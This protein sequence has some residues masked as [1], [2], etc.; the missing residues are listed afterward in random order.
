MPVRDF[1]RE[2]QWLLPPSLDTMI[3]DTHPVRYVAMFIDEIPL[4]EWRELGIDPA[5]SHYGR[6]SYSIYA[7]VGIWLY[8]F[9]TGIRTSRKLERA[10]EEQVPFLWL[11]GMEQPDFR[12]LWAFYAAHRHGM[13]QLLQRTVQVAAKA[14]LVDLAVQAID[15]TK[16][17]ANA[18]RDRYRSRTG[19]QELLARTT[20]AI[21]DLESQNEAETVPLPTLPKVLKSKER[22]RTRILAALATLPDVPES[23]DE[24]ADS[25]PRSTGVEPPLDAPETPTTVTTKPATKKGKGKGKNTGTPSSPTDP[26]DRGP[27]ANLTDP[28]AKLMQG[29]YGAIR[30]LY[31][32]QA[33]TSPLLEG[34]NREK[35]V[36][37]TAPSVSCH[38]ADVHELI[39]M[40]K[41]AEAV[42]GVRATTVGDGGYHSAANI[43]AA[44]AR[45][46]I[47]V[48]PD[49][50]TTG[51]RKLYPKAL[52]V[53]DSETDTFRC[54]QGQTLH[55]LAGEFHREEGRP[56]ATRY[57]AP[58]SVCVACP[59]QARCMQGEA[60]TQQHGRM[61]TV[62][63]DETLLRGHQELMQQE[64]VKELYAYRKTWSEATFGTLKNEQNARIFLLR[65]LDK[66]TDEWF[67]LATAFN[68]R[69]LWKRWSLLQRTQRCGLEGRAA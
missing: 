45:G 2:K 31:N 1:L 63:E 67:L 35:G 9:M 17:A 51:N 36:L 6:A 69:T 42:T 10:C 41:Q 43:A 24:P 3:L 37:I 55:R 26:V 59:V 49:T 5:G 30:P 32:A 56:P 12:T 19:L 7:L 52:F 22:L 8:G 65:G 21:A 28:D 16:I 48:I 33:V 50:Q 11:A 40:L 60:G 13:Q 46:Q 29:R 20:A 66:V 62:T 34:P 4:A 68:L 44:K 23:P 64:G 47:I 38:A 53:Y 14:G 57:R 39:P 15:G 25:A 54:P 18:S 61:V 27:R 58:L